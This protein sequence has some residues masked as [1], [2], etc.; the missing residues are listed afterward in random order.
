M[1]RPSAQEAITVPP[2]LRMSLSCDVGVTVAPGV[3]SGDAAADGVVADGVVGVRV[4]AVASA[5][6]ISSGPST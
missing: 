3:A 6:R 5:A 1:T 2:A 4:V